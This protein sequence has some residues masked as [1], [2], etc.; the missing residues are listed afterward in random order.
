MDRDKVQAAREEEIKELERRVYRVVDV[1][2]C[3]RLKGRGPIPVRWV[4]VDKGFGVH[5]SRLVA[6][7]YRP[8]SR[9]GDKEGLFAGTPP[10][11]IVKMLVLHAA[12]QCRNGRKRKLMFLDIGKAHLY[13][14]IEGDEYVDLPPERAQ[15]GKCAKLLY[16]LY[17]MRTAARSWEKEYSRTLAAAGFRIGRASPCMSFHAERDIRVVVHG[18]DFIVEGF[19]D[20]LRWVER[21][22]AAKYIVKMRGIMGPDAADTK[23]IDVLNR[24]LEWR[25]DEFRYEADPRHVEIMLRDMGLEECKAATLPG[26]QGEALEGED[27][28]F[29]DGDTQRV[30]RSVVARG[31]F[32]AQD[33]ADIRYTVK[34]LCRR[35]AAPRQFDWR[36]LKKLCRYLRGRPRVVQRM[37]I[38]Q[39]GDDVANVYVDSDWAGCRES[40]KSTNGGA[41]LFN[42][43]CL[44]C[45][46]STQTGLA[47][48][49]GEAEYYAAVKGGAE[50]LYFQSLCGDLGIEVSVRVHTD[51]SACKGICGRTGLGRVRHMDVQYLWLQQAASEGRLSLTKVP[52]TANPADLMTKYL[53]AEAISRI[54]G[55]L[56]MHWECGRNEQVDRI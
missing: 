10:L 31:N 24:I 11:E 28:A 47:L 44:R 16:T 35:M 33:R 49:S 21:L 19:E 51:S 29:L 5:R 32:L 23:V 52:G 26:A 7:D 46:S 36:R 43:A 20:D 53:S 54:M 1:E 17:G 18:D 30:Y 9:V 34:E 40:R 45:W 8:K 39:G 2:E 12:G 56:G 3:Y 27:Q 50:G 38:G 41:L 42:G 37:P 4:D 6:K 55:Q 14:P 25:E 22:L 13:A 48:S 15:P